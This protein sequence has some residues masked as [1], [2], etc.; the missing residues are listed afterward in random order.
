MTYKKRNGTALNQYAILLGLIVL[1]IIPVFLLF[2]KQITDILSGYI[3][4]YAGMNSTMQANIN[5][6]ASSNGSSNGY[7]AFIRS[8]TA[9]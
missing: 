2:G 6:T 3:N 9:Y 5:P 7:N 1:A 4:Q 8:T